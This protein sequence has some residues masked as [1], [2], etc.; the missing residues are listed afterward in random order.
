MTPSY[1]SPLANHLW[2]STLCAIVAWLLT[3]ALRNNRAALRYWIW[4]AASAKFLI[5]FSLLVAAGSQLGWRAAPASAQPQ[6]SFVMEEIGRPFT[7][8]PPTV[9]HVGERSAGDWLPGILFGVWLGGSTIA[10]I[11]WLRLWRRISTIQRAATPLSLNLPLEVFS[12]SARLEPGVFG[13]LRPV[14]LLPEGITERLSPLQ[15]EAVLA[16]E[17]CL[18]RRR[19]NL[20]ATIHMVMEA[21]FWFHPL[22]WWIRERLVEERERA[23]DEGVLRVTGNPQVY[24]EGILNVCKF[25]LETPLVCVSGVT[26]SNLKR[27]IEAIMANRTA[28]S[29]NFGR[30]L[31]LATVAVAAI[32]GPIAIGILYALPS[33]AQ[34]QAETAPHTFDAASVKPNRAGG[35]TTRR[36]EPGTITYLNITLGEFIAMAYGVKHYQLSGPDWIVNYGSTDRYDVVA[37]AAAA[38]S[39]EPLQR[40][41]GPLLVDR[42]HLA[43]HRETRELPVYALVI[44]KGGPKFKLG[45]GGAMSTR[46]DGKGGYS[47]KN[48]AMANLAD[49]LSLMNSVGRPVLDR[50]GLAGGYSFDADLYNIP[51]GLSPAEFKE[52]MVNSDAIFSTLPD[53]LGLK[54]ESQKAPI[55]IIVVDHADKVPVEN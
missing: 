53:Q 16:H 45:D 49:Q 25:Y 20:T 55:E 5:P 54:L 50:T 12:S 9:R 34:V 21:I 24:A 44:A 8:P 47:Y 23:C 13:I 33:R 29:L 3:L 46:P 51:K 2:Q 37:K 6:L 14:L 18:V 27:R 39:A 28:V 22:V 42:F 31:L 38:V 26:G 30:I 11:C 1:L 7:P 32:A 19:D 48:W 41:L 52:A 35:G 36:I 15:L 40:M 17:L 43:F 10:C 4:L